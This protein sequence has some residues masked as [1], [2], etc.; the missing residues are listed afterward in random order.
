LRETPNRFAGW[1][2]VIRPQRT[3]PII[4]ARNRVLS[5]IEARFPMAI[6]KMLYIQ[7]QLKEFPMRRSLYLKFIHLDR[8]CLTQACHFTL[9]IAS[10]RLRKPCAQSSNAALAHVQVE[11]APAQPVAPFAMAPLLP[12]DGQ[13]SILYPASEGDLQDGRRSSCFTG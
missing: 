11:K 2:A 4:S 3:F 8:K 12:R 7:I 6:E 5:G 10:S 1:D 13:H 9:L